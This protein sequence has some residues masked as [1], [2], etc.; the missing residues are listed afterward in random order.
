M[1]PSDWIYSRMRATGRL[2]STLIA[3]ALIGGCAYAPEKSS[4]VHLME[5]PATIPAFDWAGEIGKVIAPASGL[6]ATLEAAE[7]VYTVTVPRS[8][9]DV[10]IDGMHV[11][12]SA[13]IGSTFH[14]YRCSCGKMSVL[15]EFIVADYEANDVID[16]LRAGNLIRVTAV[17]PIAIGDKPKLLSLRFHGE[18]EATPLAKLIRE[19]MRWTG[20]ERMKPVK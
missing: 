5:T 12:T 3:A 10:S 18:G 7:Q 8:D 6:H 11:P 1:K 19:G 4:A 2:V 13:G 17:S 20:E 16:A 15:G 14:F 9:L